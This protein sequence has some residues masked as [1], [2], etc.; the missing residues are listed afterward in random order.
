MATL[1]TEYHLQPGRV[2][3]R[4][5]GWATQDGARGTNPGSH[6]R[7]GGAGLP[8][9]WGP[10]LLLLCLLLHPLCLVPSSRPSQELTSPRLSSSLASLPWSPAP[11]HM[12]QVSPFRTTPPATY[13]PWGCDLLP[14][15]EATGLACGWPTCC[16]TQVL[17][18]VPEWCESHFTMHRSCR[19]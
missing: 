10:V 11:Q 4:L 9:D 5:P 6:I 16:H 18:N 19:Q 14:F 12:P 13:A 3:G 15:P 17:T 8:G 7:R 2:P 1:G